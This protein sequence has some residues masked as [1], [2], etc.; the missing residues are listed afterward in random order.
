MGANESQLNQL[1]AANAIRPQD[2]R[3]LNNDNQSDIVVGPHG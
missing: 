3:P 2:W 1:K